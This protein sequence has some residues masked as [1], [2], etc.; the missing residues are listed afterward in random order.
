MSRTELLAT[1]IAAFF[2]QLGNLTE[3]QADEG[4]SIIEQEFDGDLEAA[5]AHVDAELA[6]EMNRLVR[7]AA[8]AGE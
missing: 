1:V 4:I 7:L 2:G 3:A 6:K 5:R 8:Q